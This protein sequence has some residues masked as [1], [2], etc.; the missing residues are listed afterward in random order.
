MLSGTIKPFCS[1]NGITSSL[2]TVTV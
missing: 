2:N 1:G